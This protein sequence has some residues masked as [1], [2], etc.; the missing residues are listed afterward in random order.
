MLRLSLLRAPFVV[1]PLLL[2]SCGAS[3]DGPVASAPDASG[4]DVLPSDAGD[5]AAVEA[6][7]PEAGPDAPDDV[8]TTEASDDAPIVDAP[9][10]STPCTLA[11]PYSSLNQVCNAC[12]EKECCVEINTCLLDPAC[13]D[14]YVNCI[15]ACSIDT[16]AGEVAPCIAICDE[17]Y[18]KGKAEYEAAIGCAD[19]HCAAE[20]G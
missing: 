12:A 13:D 16:D 2:A 5:E 20:C 3:D 7:G 9:M 17:D 15:L 10:D 14:S 1:L 19:A 6:A 11:R 18:P 8:P 4:A